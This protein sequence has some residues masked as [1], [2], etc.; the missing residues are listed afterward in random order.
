M[1]ASVVQAAQLLVS[2]LVTNAVRHTEPTSEGA[3]DVSIRPDGERLHVEVRDAG[4]AIEA[5]RSNGT[6]SLGFGLRLVEG[7]ASDWGTEITGAGRTV[8]FE[9][10]D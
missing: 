1:P 2:E 10:A 4:H 7:L 5:G 3:I 6:P 9:V 8:W